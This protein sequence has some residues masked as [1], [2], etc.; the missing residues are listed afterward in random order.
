MAGQAEGWCQRSRWIVQNV[1]A[2]A[3]SHVPVWPASP[4][5]VHTSRHAR[6]WRKQVVYEGT[7]Y[8]ESIA[9]GVNEGGCAPGCRIRHRGCAPRGPDHAQEEKDVAHACGLPATQIR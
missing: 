4:L 5:S 7:G 9:V 8:E 3:E 1:R 2:P 6:C